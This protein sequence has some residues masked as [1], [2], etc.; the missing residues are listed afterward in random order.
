MGAGEL[1]GA[2]P[3]A[4]GC[5][6]EED[7]ERERRK[8]LDAIERR[9]GLGLSRLKTV[10]R[11]AP[12]PVSTDGIATHASA[13]AAQARAGS[14]T[15]SPSAPALAFAAVDGDVVPLRLEFDPRDSARSRIDCGAKRRT[16]CPEGL[17]TAGMP[18]VVAE[19]ESGKRMRAAEGAA[20]RAS[21]ACAAA[22][23]T[24]CTGVDASSSVCTNPR[25]DAGESGSAKRMG[26][27]ARFRGSLI[28][29]DAVADRLMADVFGFGVGFS[30]SQTEQCSHEPVDA[31]GE[32]R[33]ATGC[34]LH[35]GGE[36]DCIKV[37]ESINHVPASG[38]VGMAKKR[39]KLSL[40]R[41][42]R[43]NIRKLKDEHILR[44][45]A[46]QGCDDIKVT[47]PIGFTDLVRLCKAL[48][49]NTSTRR[50]DLDGCGVGD[51]GLCDMRGPGELHLATELGPICTLLQRNTTIETIDLQYNAITNQGCKSLARVLEQN[52]SLRELY[53]SRNNIGDAGVQ[54][55]AQAIE[56]RPPGTLALA[57]PRIE[58]GNNISAEALAR[59]EG[60]QE[61]NS[62]CALVFSKR[63]AKKIKAV[64]L[65]SCP[66]KVRSDGLP[67]YR[68]RLEDSS[69]DDA[70][71]GS[72]ADS[73][74]DVQRASELRA[75]SSDD[76]K[77]LLLDASSDADEDEMNDDLFAPPRR[78]LPPDPPDKRSRKA[79]DKESGKMLQGATSCAHAQPSSFDHSEHE[80]EAAQRKSTGSLG[81]KRKRLICESSEE[82]VEEKRGEA[83]GDGG[84]WDTGKA[85][86]RSGFDVGDKVMARYSDG[87]WFP[88]V[89]HKALGQG[90][91]QL[92]EVN[93]DDGDAHSRRK[94]SSEM[95]L[96][97]DYEKRQ[98]HDEVVLLDDDDEVMEEEEE[99]EE[100]HQQD[101][102]VVGMDLELTDERDD[103][104]NGDEDAS[105][106]DSEGN[107]AG[108]GRA[109]G[110]E[111]GENRQALRR[112]FDPDLLNEVSAKFVAKADKIVANVKKAAAKG[113]ARPEVDLRGPPLHSPQQLGLI[114]DRLGGQQ[115][116]M[117]KLDLK[118][119][120]RVDE[121][122]L[123]ELVDKLLKSPFCELVWLDLSECG[124]T[125]EAIGCVDGYSILFDGLSHAID[126]SY[127]DLRGN[128]IDAKGFQCMKDRLKTMDRQLKIDILR[129]DEPTFNKW[130]QSLHSRV[131]EG[132]VDSD[133]EHASDGSSA[134]SELSEGE[135]E[136]RKRIVNPACEQE[137]RQ[138]IANP[139]QRTVHRNSPSL[140]D[141]HTSAGHGLHRVPLAVQR[142][143]ER[144]NAQIEFGDFSGDSHSDDAASDDDDF[145]TGDNTR[146]TASSSR[147]AV[148]LASA[149]SSSAGSRGK[150]E[151]DRSVSKKH[152]AG[153]VASDR[154]GS[155]SSH[156][157][158]RDYTFQNNNAMPTQW[159]FGLNLPGAMA[160]GLAPRPG[161]LGL[162]RGTANA[163]L[164]GSMGSGGDRGKHG[165]RGTDVTGFQQQPVRAQPHVPLD[166]L[167]HTQSWDWPS[168]NSGQVRSTVFGMQGHQTRGL[169]TANAAGA[170]GPGVKEHGFP[171]C[172]PIETLELLYDRRLSGRESISSHWL[173][174]GQLAPRHL[175]SIKRAHVWDTIE[176]GLRRCEMLLADNMRIDDAHGWDEQATVDFFEFLLAELRKADLASGND[177][178]R[179]RLYI[180]VL[181][182]AD[183]MLLS[184][185]GSIIKGLD[186]GLEAQ[187]WFRL[188]TQMNVYLL[189][190][191]QVMQGTSWQR[192]AEAAEG[193]D[194]ERL[195]HIYSFAAHADRLLRILLYLADSPKHAPF[196]V[197]SLNQRL[198]R[199][200]GYVAH[201]MMASYECVLELWAQIIRFQD[202][203]QKD[204]DKF[205]KKLAQVFESF[206]C[207]GP[208]DFYYT[209][210]HLRTK[211]PDMVT[212]V[213]A[214][215][216][217]SLASS[218]V[219]TSTCSKEEAMEFWWVF[220]T[221]ST[222]LYDL[223]WIPIA[224]GWDLLSLLLANSPLMPGSDSAIFANGS[225][226]NLQD[227]DVVAQLDARKSEYLLEL[228]DRCSLLATL[229]L[230]T[231]ASTK[232]PSFSNLNLLGDLSR[233]ALGGQ[234]RASKGVVAELWRLATADKGEG[235]DS[236]R[237][238][239]IDEELARVGKLPH[240]Y[241]FCSK[242]EMHEWIA[243]HGGGRRSLCGAVGMFIQ[244]LILRTQGLDHT[245]SAGC[246]DEFAKD[247][248]KMDSSLQAFL[249]KKPMILLDPASYVQEGADTT[250][251]G[252]QPCRLPYELRRFR[253]HLLLSS[254][255]TQLAP[256]GHQTVA[257][258]QQIFQRIIDTV[259][260][261]QSV[262]T[263]WHL[264]C[265]Y[266]TNDAQAR[267]SFMTTCCRV[268][269]YL[270]DRRQPFTHVAQVLCKVLKL[271]ADEISCS[272]SLA[273]GYVGSLQELKDA[274][275]EHGGSFQAA[276]D[277]EHQ[278]RF[279][280][281]RVDCAESFIERLL[282][283][284]S[285]FV[286]DWLQESQDLI[287]RNLAHS[288]HAQN[289]ADQAYEGV[290][291]SNGQLQL[292][293]SEL[294][295][296][297]AN[298][299]CSDKLSVS[300]WKFVREFINKLNDVNQHIF[301]FAVRKFGSESQS[302]LP[303]VSPPCNGIPAHQEDGNDDESFD[304]SE[305][306]N[307]VGQ[308][309]VAGDTL[310]S[311][312]GPGVLDA[313]TGGPEKGHAR[314]FSVQD[315][316]SL[317]MHLT[318]Q[319]LSREE[320]LLRLVL[321]NSLK[322][323]KEQKTHQSEAAEV[324]E[325]AMCTCSSLAVAYLRSS[326]AGMSWDHLGPLLQMKL[327]A[328]ERQASLSIFSRIMCNVRSTLDQSWLVAK[329]KYEVVQVWF[330]T[331]FD[332]SYHASHFISEPLIVNFAHKAHFMPL[333]HAVNEAMESMIVGNRPS[334]PHLYASPAAP[335]SLL[336][337][338]DEASQ[339]RGI[340]CATLFHQ[341]IQALRQFAS[342]LSSNISGAHAEDS[343]LMHMP[344]QGWKEAVRREW[345][346][347][348]AVSSGGYL[349]YSLEAF[350]VLFPSCAEHLHKHITVSKGVNS[351]MLIDICEQMFFGEV[352]TESPS[353]SRRLLISRVRCVP[354]AVLGVLQVCCDKRLVETF[355]SLLSVVLKSHSC[356]KASDGATEGSLTRAQS[357]AMEEVLS[358]LFLR[359][360]ARRGTKDELPVHM[361]QLLLRAKV[362]SA[363]FLSKFL[364]HSLFQTL[365][366]D[367]ARCGRGRAPLD[368]LALS[369][370]AADVVTCVMRSLAR[371]DEPMCPGLSGHADSLSMEI[372]ELI[373]RLSA[374]HLSVACLHADDTYAHALCLRHMDII[375]DALALLES[376][377][378]NHL[379]EQHNAP[380]S[381]LLDGDPVT[382]SKT[383]VLR[384]CSS[385]IA[386][387][388]ALAMSHNVWPAAS[389]DAYGG[390]MQDAST[391]KGLE[392]LG[393]ARSALHAALSQS[394]QDLPGK[395]ATSHTLLQLAL[396][397]TGDMVET[398]QET[399][400]A[401]R[402]AQCLNEVQAT[403][404]RL[405]RKALA[406]LHGLRRLGYDCSVDGIVV[407]TSACPM[408]GSA[409]VDDLSEHASVPTVLGSGAKQSHEEDHGDH[410]SDSENE[411]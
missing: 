160:P 289:L 50:L 384:A 207:K 391:A 98:A 163:T 330:L 176:Q 258:Q 351:N 216:Y 91:R 326:Y 120:R 301:S 272:K 74:N 139:S 144:W 315:A 407:P 308:S 348:T 46:S 117:K 401:V 167:S 307:G 64:P 343:E 183:Q 133:V 30:A 403:R 75:D 394:P 56:K 352:D 35:G 211:A 271:A 26:S 109:A 395:E 290:S 105:E 92:F 27:A 383:S 209:L 116:G 20:G 278:R 10:P 333:M 276:R 376:L 285:P 129:K 356:C 84:A 24:G 156:R 121:A 173:L 218:G 373:L 322:R 295:A 179:S 191:L 248:G 335:C 320:R 184:G 172:L 61:D 2:E 154:K 190:W 68:S 57:L 162:E 249:R 146:V 23:C 240:K 29:E 260:I 361:Q 387:R 3:G 281:K 79:G 270:V 282:E 16:T 67:D 265:D 127:V 214:L 323:L 305:A 55:L 76:D 379:S 306:E 331:M 186:A 245:I 51:A 397:A 312:G 358:L 94:N 194:K 303:A 199:G 169:H 371:R 80:E 36:R 221:L 77:P 145:S 15:T 142:L 86:T 147:S 7:R 251:D 52:S 225:L 100:E 128:K 166:V 201:G 341:R 257:A 261:P 71:W 63:S 217:R 110:E 60:A 364:V 47:D 104:A 400:A 161:R 263:S 406:V 202:D 390:C 262:N 177:L 223:F 213:P 212:E 40:N 293:G 9:L 118:G 210:P 370:A 65:A 48:E 66:S 97:A 143:E 359:G 43:M 37:G 8:R 338:S 31:G 215:D 288:D 38:G 393:L 234:S 54:A 327:N 125:N 224:G 275:A 111:G 279:Q 99:E 69:D 380:R 185:H 226:F 200:C 90:S 32:G 34:N 334:F 294:C 33:G 188:Y 95:V 329:V 363:R 328:D 324:K 122:V 372:I 246:K 332:R 138:R 377:S 362:D 235:A 93:W 168:A 42:S 266:I 243:N 337:L 241:P 357:E 205:W 88:A 365:A 228:I 256:I 103:D 4:P 381:G 405:H 197:D 398:R 171:R 107:P 264:R 155:G 178:L 11:P 131:C 192:A 135:E 389:D 388:A 304:W 230:Q 126:I 253:S 114:F 277:A 85:R 382:S 45:E 159:G 344:L 49:R 284:L 273:G 59:L 44:I 153:K 130:G 113:L 193:A 298:K 189:Q 340:R 158:A 152:K 286:T 89:V 355:A 247:F 198:T 106:E 252:P 366:T 408:T 254:L 141:V 175:D 280:R 115:T 222:A 39:S 134:T 318:K 402:A 299:E 78:V 182:K 291:M 132:F 53:V 314:S 238:H 319:I 350:A 321:A 219:S 316:R 5:S 302:L 311:A 137:V 274:A 345:R 28:D 309:N 232:R 19:E 349:I 239:A 342:N 369:F 180:I 385:V 410:V 101:R 1:S 41:S 124:L 244:N 250:G 313:G 296:L 354:A 409:A 136:M 300:I 255:L 123:Q 150:H 82:E 165:S 203:A 87:Q 229:W 206:R 81:T 157:S 267:T 336:I 233:L 325:Q 347:T 25:C 17:T 287:E 22:G 367:D 108:E 360:C 181:R 140:D 310:M 375:G 174:A 148:P 268:I 96:L 283:R 164:S 392:H 411:A 151:A 14:E 242:R 317:A 227:I 102:A 353:L 204:E 339:Q 237:R 6:R 21:P 399:I 346:E 236:L 112:S 62:P 368:Q 196:M 73:S 231:D 404:T 396:R 208:D 195:Q 374:E 83:R 259:S 119:Q 386:C 269:E 12:D 58:V 292:F 220:T 18:E 72:E 13:T 170:V 297:L 149:G 187:A 378:P 70:A